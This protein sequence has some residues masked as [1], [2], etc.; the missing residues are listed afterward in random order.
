M[1]EQLAPV[2]GKSWLDRIQANRPSPASPQ[3]LI[4]LRPKVSEGISRQSTNGR[5]I[6]SPMQPLKKAQLSRSSRLAAR[7]KS[8]PDTKRLAKTSLSAACYGSA[9]KFMT[10]AR[11]HSCHDKFNSRRLTRTG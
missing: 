1:R 8:C 7:L 3:F 10:A 4:S 11:S 6:N 2:F 5:G 9:A